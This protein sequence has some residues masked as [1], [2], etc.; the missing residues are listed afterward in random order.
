MRVYVAG[1]S[2]DLTLVKEIICSIGCAGHEVTYN[3]TMDFVED[4]ARLRSP[5]PSD[6][7]NQVDE[8]KARDNLIQNIVHSIVGGINDAEVVVLVYTGAETVGTWV[9]LGLCLA[10]GSSV[11]VYAP[12]GSPLREDGYVANPFLHPS[13][14]NLKDVAFSIYEVI[15]TLNELDMA[16]ENA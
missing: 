3:W 10:K 6:H 14:C 16:K 11:I 12:E 13:K 1:P 4:S 9:E 15:R 5:L 7:E 2:K 8:V